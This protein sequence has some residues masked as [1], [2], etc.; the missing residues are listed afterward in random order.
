RR[1][2]GHLMQRRFELTGRGPQI[3]QG[4]LDVTPGAQAVMHGFE[5]GADEGR[6]TLLLTQQ[7]E[8]GRTVRDFTGEFEPWY[9][10]DGEEAD[11]QH[12]DQ[13]QQAARCQERPQ[14]FTQ[15]RLHELITPLWL[16]PL[17]DVRI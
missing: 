6:M 17:T 10:H 12:D 2:C 14:D 16:A 11:S 15:T 4:S 9:E 5:R 7:L 3:I 1:R 8:C 13:H